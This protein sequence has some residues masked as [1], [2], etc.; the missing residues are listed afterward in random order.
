MCDPCA[1]SC[2]NCSK[3][4][5]N[6]TVCPPG[7]YFLNFTCLVTCPDGYF[8]NGTNC[9]LCNWR[10]LTCTNTATNCSLCKP[11]IPA[12]H[13]NNVCYSTCPNGYYGKLNTTINNTG[14]C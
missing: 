14:T 13:L 6:C 1:S 7:L 2:L 5:T 4:S 10:C 12:Y 11:S 8:A 3:I 9:S